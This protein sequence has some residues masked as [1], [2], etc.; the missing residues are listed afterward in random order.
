MKDTTIQPPSSFIL[1]S[2]STI[3]ETNLCH[4]SKQIGVTKCC[5]ISFAPP[6]ILFQ[7]NEITTMLKSEITKIGIITMSS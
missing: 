5:L 3:N 7:I 6:K 1:V 2:A 4:T